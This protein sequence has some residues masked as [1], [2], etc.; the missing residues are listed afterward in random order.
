MLSRK[1]F[2]NLHSMMAILVLVE[3]VLRQVVFEYFALNFE[4]LTKYR[5]DAIFSHVFDF[6]VP[7]QSVGIIVVEEVRNYGKIVFIKSMVE[8]GPPSLDPPLTHLV[9]VGTEIA[10]PHKQQ[11]TVPAVQL[12]FHKNFSEHR[13]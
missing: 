6:C 5:Y 10:A 2:E 8:K 13:L 12:R 7:V 1:M 11:V 9:T 4:V 3:Q